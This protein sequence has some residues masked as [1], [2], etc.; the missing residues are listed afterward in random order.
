[1]RFQ[2]QDMACRVSLQDP[3]A[4]IECLEADGGVILT[5][6]SSLEDVEQ[7]NADAAP[8]IDAIVDEVSPCHNRPRNFLRERILFLTF[9]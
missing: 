5:G 1:V 9:D 7:V 8:F 4:A 3:I 6:F 2:V